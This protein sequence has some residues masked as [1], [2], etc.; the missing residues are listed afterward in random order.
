MCV[1]GAC[2]R[3]NCFPQ[4]S[5]AMSDVKKSK[6]MCAGQI[7]ELTGFDHLEDLIDSAMAAVGEKVYDVRDQLTLAREQARKRGR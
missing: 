7:K 3:P 1:I 6:D 2:T 5:I 4:L